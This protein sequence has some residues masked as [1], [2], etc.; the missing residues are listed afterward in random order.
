MALTLE[1]RLRRDPTPLS[2]GIVFDL[3]Q[4]ISFLNWKLSSARNLILWMG[5]SYYHFDIF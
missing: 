4:N 2:C 3:A 1:S 5:T